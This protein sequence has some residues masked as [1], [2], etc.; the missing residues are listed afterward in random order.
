MSLNRYEQA[1]FDYVERNPEECRHWRAKITEVTRSADPGVVARQ[2]DRDL[3]DYFA[4]RT[5]Q[6]PAL[7]DIQSGDVRRVSML[8]L[9]DYLIRLWGPLQKPK[10]TAS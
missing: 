8:N 10:R 2:L 1:L 6:V 9:A 3:W 4:E 7:R 5:S